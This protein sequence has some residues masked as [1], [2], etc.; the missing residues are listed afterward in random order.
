MKKFLSALLLSFL[1]VWPVLACMNAFEIIPGIDAGDPSSHF[2]EMAQVNTPM[3]ED[4]IARKQK[5]CD[6]KQN[7]TCSDIAV[8]YI[9]LK[10][11]KKALRL[12]EELVKKY[13]NEYSVVITHAVALEL[14]GQYTEAL[15]HLKKAIQIN[16][17]SH[18][19]SEWIHV[20]ILENAIH[21]SS[22]PQG[23][24]L[25]FDFGTGETPVNT[26]N[27]DLRKNITELHYQL[28]DRMYFVG[29][30]DPVFGSMLFD[31]ADML[32]LHG[33]TGYAYLHY[34]M[35]RK[36]GFN[37]PYMDDRLYN[38]ETFTKGIDQTPEHTLHNFYVAETDADVLN[39]VIAK[40][41]KLYAK[42]PT[43]NGIHVA[44]GYL[45][46]KQYDSA[47]VW[48][49]RVYAQF[50]NDRRIM[51]V[52]AQILEW[53]GKPAESREVVR[54]IIALDG[55]NCQ[56]CKWWIMEKL[57]DTQI[58]P[59]KPILNLD[60]GTDSMPQNIDH[61]DVEGQMFPLKELIEQRLY[62]EKKENNPLFG[63]L[64]FDYANL[65][66]L[67]DHVTYSLDFYKKAEQYGYQSDVLA[68]RKAKVQAFVDRKDP[69]P[70][71]GRRQRLKP[72]I[73]PV[74]LAGLGVLVLGGVFVWIR[75]RKRRNR[76]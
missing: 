20:K 17:K 2:V 55:E 45:Y 21:G 73:K 10:K 3:V 29:K 32:A 62:F 4:F 39:E 53:S 15:K 68:K 48:G 57:L 25:G 19:G 16:P 61:I 63:S 22:N 75:R 52:Q 51:A 76:A 44:E 11:F 27:I 7:E 56:K 26:K 38:V 1:L 6:K 67:I 34:I 70:K 33:S 72:Y 58:N 47:L 69:I 54:K 18:E 30:K 60:F 46:L 40:D 59:G 42:K 12:T 50:P 5:E 24:I 43:R 74:A 31:Y 23:S 8:G 36:Y 13:P 71:P 49:N 65:L 9:Y 66:V 28:N 41:K 64:I 37:P 35:A 14:D